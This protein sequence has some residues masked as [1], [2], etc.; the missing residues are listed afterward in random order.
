MGAKFKSKTHLL[1]G[2]LNFGAIFVRLAS[3]FEKSS[4]TT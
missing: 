3:T 1:N 2:F 4:I